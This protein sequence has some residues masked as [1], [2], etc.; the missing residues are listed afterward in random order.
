MSPA[1]AS[2]PG[3]RA[4]SNSRVAAVITP[5]NGQAF[6]GRLGQE[7]SR[8]RY[9]H[10][11]MHRLGIETGADP[12][13]RTTIRVRRSRSRRMTAPQ[14]LML[15]RLTWAGGNF[16]GM[17]PVQYR[18]APALHNGMIVIGEGSEA[19]ILPQRFSTLL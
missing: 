9:C 3:W 4:I 19:T 16:N 2:S 1:M 17:M 18:Q 14:I 5:K 12:F 8:G 13:D 11:E 15:P 7:V 10:S 6:V